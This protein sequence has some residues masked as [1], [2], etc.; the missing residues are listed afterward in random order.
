MAMIH[1]MNCRE[2]ATLLDSEALEDQTWVTRVQ[3]R[4][5]LWVCWHCRLM[6][7]Q[8][9]WMSKVARQ[10]ISAIPQPDADFEARLLRKLSV[11]PE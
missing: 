11:P 2:I 8:V 6:A 3:F 4:V 1:V 7:R 9:R 10:S 5:H